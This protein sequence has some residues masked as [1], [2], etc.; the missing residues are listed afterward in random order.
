MNSLLYYCHRTG[1][2]VVQA[3]LQLE[4]HMGSPPET[5]HL[6]SDLQHPGSSRWCRSVLPGAQQCRHRAARHQHLQPLCRPGLT[7]G[8]LCY[9][10]SWFFFL[11]ASDNFAFKGRL[12]CQPSESRWLVLIRAC[13]YQGR[14]DIFRRI[15][16]FSANI[17]VT[18]R[19]V[20]TVL[21]RGRWK[22][23][24]QPQQVQHSRLLVT[25]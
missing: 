18:L 19:S 23:K 1:S 10:R 8:G 6:P 24:P 12:I 21:N 9:S 20:F 11:S 7:H 16:C 17:T 22:L 13:K 15:S 2:V 3:P 4:Q 14:L 5:R 25:Y